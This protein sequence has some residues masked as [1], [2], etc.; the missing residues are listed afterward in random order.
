MFTNTDNH[1]VG[2]IIS[3]SAQEIELKSLDDMTMKIPKTKIDSIIDIKVEFQSKAGLRYN[4]TIKSIRIN[5]FD[6]ITN[7]GLEVVLQ[8]VS[9][10]G[11][12]SD[13]EELMIF[14]KSKFR[15]IQYSDSEKTED[16]SKGFKKFG[17][18]FGTPGT[19]GFI[20]AS[21]NGN[22]CIGM[23]GGFSGIQ[24]NFGVNVL[25]ESSMELNLLLNISYMKGFYNQN[26]N[27]EYYSHKM[28]DSYSISMGPIF[29]FYFYGFHAQL[30]TAI[31]STYQ[32]GL[33]YYIQVGFVKRF[34]NK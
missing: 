7:D 27:D 28:D 26:R 14:L 29:E 6:F 22:R 17:I 9:L 12:Y 23:S 20:F 3:D 4:G 10:D 11:Y 24:L 34:G 33:P 16:I 5:D 19:L 32:K 13:N 18:A 8:F 25:I 31:L 21:N 2:F 1:F 30:G 15:K